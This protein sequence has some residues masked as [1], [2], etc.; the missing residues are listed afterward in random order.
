MRTISP[1]CT[2]PALPSRNKQENQLLVRKHRTNQPTRVWKTDVM[3][4]LQAAERISIYLTLRRGNE[5]PKKKATKWIG[6]IM[7][8]NLFLLMMTRRKTNS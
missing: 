2:S 6:K 3:S 5:N 1:P 4:L 7:R 8:D